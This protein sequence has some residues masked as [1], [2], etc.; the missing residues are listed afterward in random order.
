MFPAPPTLIWEAAASEFLDG[1]VDL[2]IG[3]LDVQLAVERVI[4]AGL[5]DD[6]SSAVD[7]SGRNVY[8]HQVP[9]L[10]P[11]MSP[12]FVVTTRTQHGAVHVIFASF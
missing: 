12:I 6:V 2:D 1:L 7:I 8:V 3:Y 10:F 9:A 5:L 4:H 11:N